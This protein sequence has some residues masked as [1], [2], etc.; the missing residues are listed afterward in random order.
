V[1]AKLAESDAPVGEGSS[2]G[3]RPCLC[4]RPEHREVE[5]RCRR[6]LPGGHLANERRASALIDD[7]PDEE[8][9]QP[10]NRGECEDLEEAENGISPPRRRLD[11]RP[12]LAGDRSVG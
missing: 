9:E 12:G 2:K 5:S 10:G 6:F 8:R 4:V 7:A 1:T 3:G 11:R